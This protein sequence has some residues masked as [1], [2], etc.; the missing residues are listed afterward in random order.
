[1]ICFKMIWKTYFIKV[2]EC[3]GTN[4]NQISNK[5]KQNTRKS[6]IIYKKGKGKQCILH[7]KVECPVF[8]YVTNSVYMEQKPETGK[9]TDKTKNTCYTS[10]IK[11]NEKKI[12]EETIMVI[13]LFCAAGM[14]TSLLVK[15][16]EE[17]AK[18]KGKDADIAA[19]PFTEM[20]RVI[21]GVDVA[22]LG[23]QVGYQLA[24]AKEI[25][26]PKGVP[27]DVIPMQDYGMCN[28]M[29]VLK[30]AYKLAKNK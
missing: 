8:F 23:P 15:K 1:M 19:Y 27:V 12:R 4:S 22:L 29:N 18:E 10:T 9:S 28:G 21:E 20:E 24:R 3:N 5:K 2:V 25:C 16:M 11:A 17:A 26:D 6:I 14:S 13:R 30:F 7:N